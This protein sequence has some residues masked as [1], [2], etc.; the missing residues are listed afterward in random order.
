MLA[1]EKNNENRTT[2]PA[3]LMRWV[4]VSCVMGAK[5]LAVPGTLVHHAMMA[6]VRAVSAPHCA[7]RFRI[8]RILMAASTAGA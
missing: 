1:V 2:A 6:H 4:T 7:A 8:L 5:R 3:H